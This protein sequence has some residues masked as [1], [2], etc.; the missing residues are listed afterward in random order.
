MWTRKCA[1]SNER[2]LSFRQRRNNTMSPK[3][4]AANKGTASLTLLYYGDS[5]YKTIAQET[6]KLKQT[7]DGY[8]FKVL[9]KDNSLPS[10]LDLS[11]KDE[12]LADVKEEPTKANLFK[13]LIEL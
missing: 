13:Y 7:M 3:S 10:W 12:K 4:P 9:L 1:S 8:D 2:S 11:E 6:L 5:E